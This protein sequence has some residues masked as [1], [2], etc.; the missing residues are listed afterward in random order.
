M[1]TRVLLACLAFAIV[2]APVSAADAQRHFAVLSLIGD[3]LTVVTYEGATGTHLDRNQHQSLPVKDPVFDQAA[4]F[5]VDDALKL[6]APGATVQLLGA[7]PSMYEHEER[8]FKGS[9]AVLPPELRKGMA[10]A[11]HLILITK[12]RDEARLKTA[13]GAIGAGSIEGLGFYIDKVIWMTRSDTG[14]SAQGML[15]P[16]V[17]I[18]ASLIDLQ[19]SSVLSQRQIT[20][21]TTLS[22][23]RAEKGINPWDALPAA[24]KVEILRNIINEEL[25]RVVPELL[26]GL[27]A[28]EAK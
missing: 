5:A 8:F 6:R 3:A 13:Q 16:F 27:K 23:G 7:A 17:Y 14:E 26:A 2:A 11:T 1:R 24:K 18:K 25:T 21:S 19:S 12:H 15:G 4:L 28:G 22:A 20:A 10:G 9:T